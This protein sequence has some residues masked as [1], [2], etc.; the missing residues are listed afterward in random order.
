M[1]P[2]ARLFPPS[3]EFSVLL[4]DSFYCCSLLVFKYFDCHPRREHF[5]SW[6]SIH[7]SIYYIN[8]LYTTIVFTVWIVLWF[9]ILFL[10][11]IDFR[12]LCNQLTEKHQLGQLSLL[13]TTVVICYLFCSHI[14]PLP[15]VLANAL[16]PCFTVR[17]ALSCGSS[18]CHH[19]ASFCTGTIHSSV[20]SPSLHGRGF[21]S[22]PHVL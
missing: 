2:Q 17:E 4:R 21:F 20:L 9:F 12:T 19:P 13:L 16:A 7:I 8:L 11:N 15:S 10:K 14:W 3:P 5:T 18:A 22:S 1:P 6:S